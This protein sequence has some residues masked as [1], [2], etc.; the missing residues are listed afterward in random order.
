MCMLLNVYVIWLGLFNSSGGHPVLLGYVIAQHNL[1]Q[2]IFWGM[3]DSVN[4]LVDQVV[5]DKIP[6][7]CTGV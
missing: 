1:S 2:S 4:S 7:F 5:V 6:C 3:H